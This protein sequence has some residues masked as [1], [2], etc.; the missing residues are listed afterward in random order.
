MH[1]ITV[2]GQDVE[3]VWSCAR[4]ALEHARSG[5]GRCS[6]SQHV[7][8]ARPLRRRSAGVSRQGRVQQT[9]E[10]QDPLDKLRDRL[11]LSDDEWESSTRRSRRSSRNRSSSQSGTDPAPEDALK[12][13][14]A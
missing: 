11:E 10:T 4:E 1:S 13:V 3:E 7:P 9:R 12:N 6:S 5:P 2:D 14:Y 8:A